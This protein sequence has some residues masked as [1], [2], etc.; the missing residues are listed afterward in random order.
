MNSV[1]QPSFR[2]KGKSLDLSES[3]TRRRR[4]PSK[5][6]Q[7]GGGYLP[8]GLRVPDDSSREDDDD[9]HHD[10]D[11]SSQRSFLSSIFGGSRR[12]LLSG[13]GSRMDS[14]RSLFRREGRTR[15]TPRGVK[16]SSSQKTPPKIKD[17]SQDDPTEG[18]SPCVSYKKQMD[19]NVQSLRRGDDQGE[20]AF[21]WQEQLPRSDFVPP[22]YIIVD[23]ANTWLTEI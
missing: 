1:F 14:R 13:M 5:Q 21:D 7:G 19:Q 15:G 23:T 8:Q 18:L 17:S 16:E 4:H 9:H 2:N 10:D 6:P 22:E 20:P 11:D 12:S 3:K